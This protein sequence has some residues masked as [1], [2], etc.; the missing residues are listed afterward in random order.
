MQMFRYGVAVLLGSLAF[1]APGR[2]QPSPADPL[3]F[4]FGYVLPNQNQEALATQAARIDAL[5][6]DIINRDAA[7]PGRSRVPES[8][9]RQSDEDLDPNNIGIGRLPARGRPVA[10]FGDM[11]G[12]FPG[13][14][15]DG[16]RR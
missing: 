2:A 10:T 9:L 12:Y 4:Y 7:P 15:G 14:R 13:R 3:N 11:R 6:R 5:R 1:P 8:R 16:R